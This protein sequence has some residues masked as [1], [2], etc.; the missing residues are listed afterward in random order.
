MV[1][2]NITVIAIVNEI[3][4]Y[5]SNFNG[6]LIYGYKG[7]IEGFKTDLV[8]SINKDGAK[9]ILEYYNSYL[10]SCDGTNSIEEKRKELYN[11]ILMLEGFID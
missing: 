9:E 5:E 8:S 4:K 7:D 10:I 6:G 1:K 3:V 11:I 2:N